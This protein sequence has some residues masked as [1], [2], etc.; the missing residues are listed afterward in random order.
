MA[1]QT[2][3]EV[4]VVTLTGVTK[5]PNA[6]ALSIATVEGKPVVFR[7][8]D[9]SEGD[10]AVYIPVDALVPTSRPEFAFLAKPGTERH[11]IRAMRLRGVF[12]MGLLIKPPAGVTPGVP[13]VDAADYFGIE[14]YVPA[15]ELALEAAAAR[16]YRGREAKAAGGLKLPVYGLDSG[17]KYLGVLDPGEEVVITEKI[18]GTNARYCYHKGRLWAGSHKVMRGCSR[19]RLGEAFDRLKLKVYSLFGRKHRAHLFERAG[20]VWWEIAE[21]EGLKEKLAHH[22]DMVLYGEIYGEKVQDLTYDSPKGRKFRAFDVYDLKAGKF[23]DWDDFL[24]FC[25]AADIEHVP[26][27]GYGHVGM[28]AAVFPAFAPWREEWQFDVPVWSLAEGKSLLANHL[29]EGVVA[30]PTTERVDPHM[31]RVALKLVGQGYLLRG[32]K[33]AA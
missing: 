5:H 20:D 13:W 19:S 4:K 30:K 1:E 3:F 11:R 22:P 28:D 21:Q 27:V 8:A 33:E 32:E 15:S 31:G 29:R 24:D 17:R 7:T 23:L 18:H 26:V 10:T 14:K 6:D 12:S 9:F 2:E 16:T 25:A